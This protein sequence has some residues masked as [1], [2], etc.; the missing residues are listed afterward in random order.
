MAKVLC[1][2]ALPAPFEEMVRPRAS[3]DVLGRIVPTSELIDQLRAA[4]VDVLC[5]Q[6]RDP[7][8]PAVLD[9]GLPRLRCVSL[10]AVGYNNVDVDAATD[11]GIAVANTPGVLT[12]ATADC[13]M[14]LLLAATR[15]I[16]EGDAAMRQGLFGGWAPDY[17]L[18]MELTGALLGVVGFGRIGQAVARRALGF[19]MRVAYATDVEVT[20]DD[21]IR[22]HVSEQPFGDL[23]TAAD[24]V[25]LHV[26]LTASTH[27]LIDETALRSM[28]STAVL[29]NTS[30]GAVIDEV[31]LVRALQQRWI[32][33]AGLDVYENEPELA[34]ALRE[35]RSAVLSPHL[36]SATVTTRANMARLTAQNALDA[37]D[38]R[39]PTH[40]VNPEV[41]KAGAPPPAE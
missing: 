27:H 15:R 38:G 31:A 13:T 32:A 39:L 18:G 19:G 34:P 25:S 29:V 37:L 40:C 41:W 33:G 1:T 2:L 26:P 23:L 12:N 16:C 24:V 11:R 4:Q 6:L 5:P 36:G 3:M 9:A 20:I 21:D 10:Y 22:D 30:R 8:T 28:R 14:A 35:C 7:I 17:M